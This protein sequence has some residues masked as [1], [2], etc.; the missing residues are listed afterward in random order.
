MK[1]K[2]PP[3]LFKPIKTW[4][5]AWGDQPAWV[6]YGGGRNGAAM[7]VVLYRM[8]LRPTVNTFADTGGEKPSTYAAIREIDKWLTDRDQPGITIVR[9]TSRRDKTLEEECLRAK[10]LPSKAYGHSLCSQVWKIEPQEQFAKTYQPFIDAWRGGKK[11]VNVIGFDAGEPG[12]ITYAAKDKYI[13]EYPLYELGLFLE[14]CQKILKEEGLFVPKSA[15][16]YCPSSKKSEIFTLQKIYPELLE[17]A[18][19]MEQ[20]ANLD[21]IK[22]LGRSYSWKDLIDDMQ[23]D[24]T[25]QPSQQCMCHGDS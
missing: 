10:V 3:R 19:H 1:K 17:R 9:N 13:D 4:I 21:V 16:Y 2:L 8:G 24:E 11:V 12:R 23:V 15:C 5:E 20:N 6:H 18:L 7:M 22:G 25:Y 14:D